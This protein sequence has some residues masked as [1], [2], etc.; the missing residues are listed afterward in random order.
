MLRL[1]PGYHLTGYTASRTRLN[2]I[3]DRASYASSARTP[4]FTALVDRSSLLQWRCSC[5]PAL[6]ISRFTRWLPRWGDIE[7][8]DMVENSVG[9]QHSVHM[10]GC[11]LLGRCAKTRCD[12]DK[13]PCS[14][15]ACPLFDRSLCITPKVLVKTM[16]RLQ[17]HIII[18]LST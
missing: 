6:A 18:L 4:W 8:M 16:A 17:R 3:L 13:W 2:L 14:N 12:T 5:C 1:P 10:P 11:I 9:G 7:S 15:I